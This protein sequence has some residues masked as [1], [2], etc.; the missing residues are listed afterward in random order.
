MKSKAEIV[1]IVKTFVTDLKTY[2]DKPRPGEYVSNKECLY[3]ILGSGGSNNAMNTGANL[4]F[5]A[6]CLFVGAIY[7]LRMMDF[8]MLGVVNMVLNYLFQPIT[9][10]ITDNLGRPPKKTMRSF[11]RRE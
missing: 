1:G 4:T 7:G 6:S 5:T 3:F 10:I 2:W 11:N 9:M 8:A